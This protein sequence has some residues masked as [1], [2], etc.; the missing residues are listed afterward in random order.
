MKTSKIINTDHGR[1]LEC[2]ECKARIVEKPFLG[3]SLYALLE[4]HF[5]DV[6]HI[7]IAE[8]RNKHPVQKINHE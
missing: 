4:K 6:H 7:T 3:L 5:V 2:F 8:W 1:T